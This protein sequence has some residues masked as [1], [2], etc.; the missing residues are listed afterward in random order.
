VLD[1]VRASRVPLLD[2]HPVFAALPAIDEVMWHVDSH[3]NEE[4]CRIVAAKVVAALE[5]RL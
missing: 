1:A 5:G 4:G 2:L 3:L